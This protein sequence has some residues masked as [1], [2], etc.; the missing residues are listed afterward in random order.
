MFIIQYRIKQF[1]KKST[2]HNKMKLILHVLLNIL[3]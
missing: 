2:L 1:K 3:F